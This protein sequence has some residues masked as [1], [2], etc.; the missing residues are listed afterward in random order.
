MYALSS[1]SHCALGAS[2]PASLDSMHSRIQS[3]FART[4]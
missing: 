2:Q 1:L 4:R 3:M